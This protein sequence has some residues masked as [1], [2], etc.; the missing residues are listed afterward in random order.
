MSN[1][2]LIADFLA[3]G[4]EIKRL[5]AQRVP[6]DLLKPEAHKRRDMLAELRARATE[7]SS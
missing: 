3:K 7:V 2:D 6:R 5:P 1:D 4:G